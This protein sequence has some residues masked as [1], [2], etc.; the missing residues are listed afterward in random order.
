MNIRPPLSPVLFVA[1]C[2]AAWSACSGASEPEARA[3]AAVPA[4]RSVTSSPTSAPTAAPDPL[5][6]QGPSQDPPQDP[7]QDPVRAERADKPDVPKQDPEETRRMV[8]EVEALFAEHGITVDPKASTVTLECVMNDPK[9]RIEFLLVSL[10]GKTHE[11]LFYTKA[12][13][14]VLN[15]ALLMAGY[16][17][18]VNFATTERDPLPT[19]QEVELG[20][21]P[22]EV[23]PP[24]GMELYMTVRWNGDDGEVV[25]R[26]VEDML[27][28]L[29]A[30]AEM[31]EARF[32][33]L[34]GR[35]DSINRGEDPVFFAD[36]EGN[37][38]ST[39]YRAPA[40]HLATIV[41]DPNQPS[42]SWWLTTRC[43][44]EGTVVDLVIHREET[45]LHRA[46][47]ERLRQE[48]ALADRATRDPNE[49]PPTAEGSGD[50][51]P[52]EPKTGGGKD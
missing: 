35:M 27:F 47:R 6:S 48:G 31:L 46:R 42:E 32:V 15:A 37:L 41:H 44:P 25:E 9:D 52:V 12:Q 2:G 49:G 7:P 4:E 21:E 51:V 34:G 24:R 10:R 19:R 33:Y 11:A 13:P 3:A 30:G 22:F 16:E 38:I 28:D 14:S 18:G 8:A 5:P 26:P 36:V 39:V 50:H 17:K 43:P 1:L 29:I 45:E 40:N 20:A 23:F